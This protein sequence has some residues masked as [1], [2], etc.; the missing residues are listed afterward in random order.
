MATRIRVDIGS[1]MILLE[2]LCVTHGIYIV[3]SIILILDLE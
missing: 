2:Y 3:T 1:S